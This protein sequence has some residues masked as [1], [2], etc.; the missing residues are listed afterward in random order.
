MGPVL[1][2]KISYRWPLHCNAIYQPVI[3]H[4]LAMLSPKHVTA[5]PR[6]TCNNF[7]DCL[8]QSFSSLT[9]STNLNFS[10]VLSGVSHW[11]QFLCVTDFLGMTLR[12]K[13]LVFNMSGVSHGGLSLRCR[14]VFVHTVV[15][16]FGWRKMSTIGI[17]FCGSQAICN[18]FMQYERSSC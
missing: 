15:H 11:M 2:V 1:S 3:N 12:E 10:N 16:I 14:P 9:S 18:L 5:N 7:D 6:G 8:S 4:I 17:E 13:G